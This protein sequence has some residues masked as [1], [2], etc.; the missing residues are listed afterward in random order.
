MRVRTFPT[1]GSNWA[2]YG[3]TS[4]PAGGAIKAV[5]TSTSGVT[6]GVWGESQSTQ[7]G[8]VYGVGDIFGVRGVSLST[9]GIGVEGAVTTSNSIAFAVQGSSLS[10]AG[11]GVYGFSTHPTGFTRGVRGRVVSSNGYAGYFEGRGYFEGA[12]GIGLLD[13]TEMLDVAG[14]ARVAGLALPT[15]AVDGYVLTSDS[16]GNATWQAAPSDLDWAHNGTHI[17][18][19]VTGNVGI[20]TANPAMPLQ[21][22]SSDTSGHTSGVLSVTNLSQTSGSQAIL[23]V[24]QSGPGQSGDRYGVVG[25]ITNAG[26]AVTGAGVYGVGPNDSGSGVL[27]EGLVGVRGTGIQAAES[28]GVEGTAEGFGGAGVLG[29]G[30]ADAPGAPVGVYGE[31][32]NP[33]G[34]GV[35][36]EALSA[37]GDTRG[38]A[39][40]ASSP[41]G[42]GV[43][44]ENTD[45]GY[46]PEA[47]GVFGRSSASWG[48]GVRG[49]NTASV[50]NTIGVLGK[51]A[52]GWG[53]RAESDTGAGLYATTGGEGP[54]AAIHGYAGNPDL[55]YYAVLGRCVAANGVAVGGLNSTTEAGFA[56]GVYGRSD[57]PTGYGV[58]SVGDMY[59]NGDF[60]AAG[61]KGFVQPHPTDPAREIRFVCLEG[62]E[63]GTYFRGSSELVDGI[64]VIDVPEVFSLVT[65]GEGLTVQVTALGPG[66]VWV[67]EKSLERIVVRGAA[68][69]AF[70]YFVNGVRRGFED[71]EPLRATR[72]Y[73][74]RE[75]GVPYG[76][77]LD[78]SLRDALVANGTLRPGL[79]ARRSDGGAPRVAPVRS[80]P[81]AAGRRG[82]RA[83]VGRM[84]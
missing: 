39:G 68:D 45:G 69:V 62:D 25:R 65:A 83:R 77:H 56:V 16:T 84:V 24:T 26:S 12:L 15:G 61:T 80:L 48:A 71:Y 59:A 63:A 81:S 78:S 64:A 27:G 32:A 33:D 37:T 13:P 4:A 50:V 66:L 19:A 58:Y 75:R 70:D 29:R 11:G 9:G 49:E 41:D 6:I 18:A 43:H 67:A 42:Y 52:S 35:F 14:T 21:V 76:A 73:L 31:A 28:W 30:D 8:G 36:G 57:S 38:V 44:G 55:A 2:M 7:G 1:S 22:V 3:S 46:S 51:T 72:A 40:R 10:A 60:D 54:A 23:G 74:P 17:W 82:V 34:A 47:A 5:A 79:H 53:V 20:G